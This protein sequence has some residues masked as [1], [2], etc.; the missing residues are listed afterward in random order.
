M[1]IE[2][3]SR[4]H[5]TLIDLN[6]SIGRVDG[7]V[8]I[9]LEKPNLKI[10]GDIERDIIIEFDN[11]LYNKFPEDFLNKIKNRAY[12]IA[13]DILNYIGKEGIYLKFLSLFPSHS[14]LGSGTQLSL[15][16]GKLITKLYNYNIDIYEI[17]KL[18]GRGGTSGIGI[19]AFKYG[20]FLLDGGH[21]WKEK[22]D[23]KPSSASKG[24]RPAPILFRHNFDFDITLIIPEG[25]HVYGKREVDI[26][27]KYCPIPLNEVEKLSHLILMKMLP[28]VVEKNLEDFGDVINKIQ[29]L[30]FKKVEVGL[31]SEVV[32]E[33]IQSLQKSAFSGL[34]SF[35]PTVYALGDKRFIIETANEVFDKFGVDG[36]IIFTKANNI[37]YKIW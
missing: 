6:A 29:Y 15:A 27:K 35:G 5:I 22:K 24:I 7:G 36:E 26:F 31:Q 30:G 4:I 21:S 8:G 16:I 28:A 9:A 34:S 3:P 1:I 32:K 13:K 2:S 14:G 18:L 33:L 19:G 20:G 12:N 23:F 17:A 11:T 37:G 10:E 25:E